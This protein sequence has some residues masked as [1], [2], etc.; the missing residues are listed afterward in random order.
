MTERLYF[1]DPYL[2]GFSAHVIARKDVSADPPIRRSAVALDRSAFYPEGGGQPADRGLLNEVRVVDVQADDEGTVWHTL[3]GI[4]DDDMVHGQVDWPRRFD[5]IQQHHGQHLLSAA[6]EELFG[7]KTVSF[8]LGPESATIDLAGD[9]G[10]AELLAAESRTNE[11]I[12]E[13]RPV[14]AR[15]V[16]AEEL[17]RLPLRKPPAVSGPIR[18]VSVPDFDYSACGGTHPKSTGTVGILHIR[19]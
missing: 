6:F 12:W 1:L 15:F 8:H 4:L 10:E 5:H 19:R 11:V 9:P 14:D 7:L 16:T 18:V 3:D 17:A 2:R 13:D